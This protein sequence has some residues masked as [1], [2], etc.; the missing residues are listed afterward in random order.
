MGSQYLQLLDCALTS[1]IKMVRF[2]YRYV[3]E[4]V[5]NWLT[6]K[7]WGK[8]EFIEFLHQKWDWMFSR[9]WLTRDVMMNANSMMRMKLYIV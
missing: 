6:I 7:G 3:T 2:P 4:Y 1:S 8:K 9:N 5:N